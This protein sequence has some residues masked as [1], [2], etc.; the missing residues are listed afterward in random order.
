MKRR[1]RFMLIFLSFHSTSYLFIFVCLL[2]ILGKARISRWDVRIT[3]PAV[4][5]FFWD[6]SLLPK[7]V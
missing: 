5:S 1:L 7:Q 2:F 6:S 4:T 3:L